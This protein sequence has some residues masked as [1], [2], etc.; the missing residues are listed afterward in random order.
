MEGENLHPKVCQSFANY[1]QQI[2]NGATGLLSERDIEPPKPENLIRYEELK[3]QQKKHWEKMVVIKLNGGLGTSMGLKKAKSLLK[4]KGDFTF[5]DIICQQIL[6]MRKKQHQPIPLLFMNSFNTREDTLEYLAKYA[7]L[8]INQLPLDFLQNKFPKIR[9]D[10]LAPLKSSNEHD[11]WN[12][13]GHGE[14]Y[15]AMQITGILQ[16]LI[17]CGY[18]YAFISNSD[19]LGAVADLKILSHFAEMEI[20]FLMEV[21]HRT[22]MDKKG[23]HLAQTK[24]GQLILR[25]V[26]QCPDSE[27]NSFQDIEKYSYF[28]TNNLWVNLTALKESMQKNNDILP[29]PLILNKK[30]VDDVPVYQV[31]SAM[32]AAIGIFEGSK[33]LI[34]PRSR[35]LPVKKTN[36]LLALWSDAFDL[37]EDFSLT[38]HPSKKEIPIID[39][40]ENFSDIE[41][42]QSH[43]SEGIP[44]LKNCDFFQVKGDIYFGENV[45]C[46]SKVSLTSRQKTFLKDRTIKDEDL[47]LS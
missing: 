12:P 14:I 44:S 4:V 26:A 1:Y 38:L 31:E 30:A 20:P 9:Q 35:F 28:N 40:D 7:S 36:D 16:Q 2:I 29:L 18:E 22:E 42:L 33:A 8:K 27:I 13:P 3:N 46:E 41:L 5:L 19:N 15:L 11:N 34:V 43:F 37:N 10:N 17:D 47:I 45:T 24:S 39:L 23:G 6:M 32:G 21:C 25:E